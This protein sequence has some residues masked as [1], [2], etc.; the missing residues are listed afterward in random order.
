MIFS[1]TALDKA[2]TAFEKKFKCNLCMHDYCGQLDHSILP[3]EHVNR[4]CTGIKKNHQR[5]RSRCILFDQTLLQQQFLKSQKSF[6][7]QCP[8]G[9]TEGVF[10]ILSGNELSGCMFA[11][12]FTGDPSGENEVFRYTKML[13]SPQELP[14]IPDDEETFFAF[15]ELIAES[16]ATYSMRRTP[17]PGTA[18]EI[19]AEFFRTRHRQNVGL[20]DAAE[21]LGLTAARASEKIKREFGRNFAV[22]LTEHRLKTA[23]LLLENSMFTIEQIARQSGFSCGSYF[24]RVFKKHFGITPEQWRQNCSQE[25]S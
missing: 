20:D 9:V 11:G 8:F 14:E 10:P 7:K 3:Q 6:W 5:I 25:R 17:F 15:G 13:S 19:V 16:I 1:K 2:I 18:R 21:L 12:V 24:F 22:L 23:C 4:Y